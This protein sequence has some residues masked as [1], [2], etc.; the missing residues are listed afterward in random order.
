M[1]PGLPNFAQLLYLM[2]VKPSTPQPELMAQHAGDNSE[3]DGPFTRMDVDLAVSEKALQLEAARDG[4][5]HGTLEVTLIAY[6][7]YGNQMNWLVRNME[8]SLS[9]EQYKAYW[10]I[11]MQFHFDFDAPRGAAYLRSGVFDLA[12]GKAGTMEVLLSA[13][14][15]V[16]QDA[17]SN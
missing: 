9:P 10:D 14:P 17:K 4:R 2:S 11:G 15:A 6:D 5:R 12:S 16:P 13:S 3:L 1:A 8:L 7:R